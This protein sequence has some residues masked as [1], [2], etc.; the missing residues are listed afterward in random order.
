MIDK[1]P[2]LPSDPHP[3]VVVIG[4][5]AGGTEALGTLVSALPETLAACVFVVRH[6]H[7]ETSASYIVGQLRKHTSLP[8]HAA[9]EG[10]V[11]QPGHICVAPTDRHLLIDES[12]VW[13]VRGPRENRWRPAIDTLFR[14]AAVSHRSRVIG[15]ILTGFLD[16]GTAGL[17]A[18]KRCGGICIVQDPDDAAFP[19]M[20]RTALA[21][22]AVDYCVPLA[23]IG[24]LITRLVAKQSVAAPAIPRDLLTEARIAR[25]AL[26]QIATVDSIGEKTPL[27][28]PDCGGVLWELNGDGIPRFRCHTGHAYTSDQLLQAQSSRIEETLWRALRMFE[29]RKNLLKTMSAGGKVDSTSAEERILQAEED[30]RRLR[31]IL[32]AGQH[33]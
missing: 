33:G 30:I 15:V 24:G 19:D 7:P 29:E 18:I 1:E 31:G 28:C 23:E 22:V 5:S 2:I 4:T 10:Q 20:P 32:Q 9:Q 14:S 25:S 26:S 21:N 16:D 12:K 6:L 3:R 17:S 27:T 13:V 11:L 8:C